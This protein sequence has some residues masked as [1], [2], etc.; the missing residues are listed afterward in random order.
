M[1]A[2]LDWSD[3][4]GYYG[5]W[6]GSINQMSNGNIEFDVN[7]FL[8]P[9]SPNVVSEVQEVT[10]TPTPQIIWKVDIPAPMNAYRAYRIP[11]LYPGVTW[12]Y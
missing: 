4:P 5:V 3:L 9:P 8:S 2:N 10:Y 12:E 7:A 1:V 6:G 11:S